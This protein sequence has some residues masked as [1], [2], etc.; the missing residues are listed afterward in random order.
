MNEEKGREA[1]ATTKRDY[2]TNV[3]A[4]RFLPLLLLLSF[5]IPLAGAGSM[6]YTMFPTQTETRVW[7]LTNTRNT[8]VSFNIIL[9]PSNPA[10]FSITAY[11]LNGT[12]AANSTFIEAISASLNGTGN[13][14][15]TVSAILINGSGNITTINEEIYI[16][17]LLTNTT[18]TT[19][20]STS[21]STTTIAPT[22][23]A[24]TT[25]IPASTTTIAN[26]TTANSSPTNSTSGNS[27]ASNKIESLTTTPANH[28]AEYII[29]AVCAAFVCIFFGIMLRRRKPEEPMEPEP[30]EEVASNE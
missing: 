17:N 12:I 19:V 8:S 1:R 18:S 23:S 21:T 5:L 7:N 3:N 24:A 22:T 10:N 25:S 6:H 29:I 30:T 20:S 11:P 15:A 13:Y 16:Y 28:N 9:P 2:H 14:S 4:L 27:S 26:S